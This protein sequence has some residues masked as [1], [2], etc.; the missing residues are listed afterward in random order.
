M[1]KKIALLFTIFALSS[2]LVACGGAAPAPAPADEAEQEESAAEQEEAVEEEPAEEEPAAEA[3]ST[4]SGEIGDPFDRITLRTNVGSDPP[5][6]DPALVTDTTSNFFVRQMFVGLTG[7]DE[8]A[9]V[10]PQLAT[11]WEVSEDGLQWTFH[12]RD[13]IQWVRRNADG[14]YE[15]LRPVVAGDV[16]YAV[17]RA[18]DPNTASDYA[19]VLYYIQGAEEANT[20]DLETADVEALMGEVGVEAPDDT[21]VVF[22]LT[23]PAAYFPSVVALTTAYPLYQEAIDEFGEEW[24]EPGNIVTNGP[25]TLLER[26]YGASIYIEKSPLWVDADDVQIEVYGGPIIAEASTEM[27]LYESN[28]IDVMGSDPGW[29]PPLPDMDRIKTDP[30]LSEELYIAPKTCTYYYGF[31]ETKPPFDDVNV[32][33]A[34]SLAIDR[35]SLID[36]VIKGEQI[37]AHSFVPPGIFG[38]VAD[39]ME[40]GAEL[41]ADYGDRITEAQNLLAEAGYPEGEGIDVVLGHNTSESHAQIAQ[42]VQAMWQE[43]FPQAQITIENQEWAV[44]LDTLDPESP[45]ENKPNIYRSAWCTDYPDANNWHNDV[46]NSKSSQ[47]YSKF[48]NDE[49]DALVLEAAFETDSATREE[50]YAEAERLLIDENA[51]IA[52]IY[53]Y[54]AIRMFKPWV[55]PVLSP[56]SGD[57]IA[58]WTIDVEAQ[59]EALS[60]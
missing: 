24:I 34:F 4:G 22:T 41:L 27:A 7:F 28:D 45:D 25:Y 12:L 9:Q 5:T 11:E 47:N 43:A 14:E 39:N 37:A 31:L 6:L 32:R 16:V 15:A 21:T 58:E 54:T 53:Y 36:N 42:V 50:L 46:F 1:Y 56:I 60:Q 55:T 49:F 51:A 30:V 40:I 48:Y 18:I 20:A 57:P 2:L 3:E 17:K 23:A 59:R 44:Y 8:E 26:N 52:P 38:N 35:Q 13:D 33:K 29:G 19:Y 10:V